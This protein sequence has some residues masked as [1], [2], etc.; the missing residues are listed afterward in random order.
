MYLKYGVPHQ[1]VLRN[2]LKKNALSVASNILLQMNAKLG[3]P[4]WQI[5]RSPILMKDARIAIGGFAIYHKLN[6]KQESCAAFVGTID[7]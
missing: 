1:N 5:A 2:S 3:E 4:L 7:N 6:S